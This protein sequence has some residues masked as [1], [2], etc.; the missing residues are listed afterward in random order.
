[1]WIACLLLGA[2]AAAGAG[3]GAVDPGFGLGGRL[4]L[5]DGFDG[6]V[7]L[8]E[9]RLQ[10]FSHANGTLSVIR[11][12]PAGRPQSDFGPGGIRQVPLPI[13]AAIIDRA[14]P[15]SD[16]S[17]LV[18]LRA[19]GAAA[20]AR[21]TL[22]SVDQHGNFEPEFGVGGVLTFRP[23]P[24]LNAQV[25]VES[26]AEAADGGFHILVNHAS[27]YFA[28][29]SHASVIHR[30]D[31][32]GNGIPEFSG[33]YEKVIQPLSGNACLEEAPV[34]KLWSLPDNRLLAS[35]PFGQF[36]FNDGEPAQLP[37]AWVERSDQGYTA[38]LDAGDQ[39]LYSTRPQGQPADQ[40]VLLRWNTDLS[41]DLYFGSLG[42]GSVRLDLSRIQSLSQLF[43]IDAI[44]LSRREGPDAPLYVSGLA[45][46]ESPRPS[47]RQERFVHRTLANG[48][49]D[50]T[51]G[52]AG[53][54]HLG[55]AGSIGSVAMAQDEGSLLFRVAGEQ[56]RYVR[57]ATGRSSGAGLISLGRDLCY[58]NG[59]TESAGDFVVPVQ[60]TVGSLG[61]VSVRYSARGLSATAGS[62]FVAVSGVLSWA[63]G[64]AGEKLIHLPILD[65]PLA[66]ETEALEILLEPETGS[67]VISC[68]SA[69]VNIVS[70]EVPLPTGNT[71][72]A[73]P[74]PSAP[75]LPQQPDLTGGSGSMG[76]AAL[77]LLAGTLLARMLHG[78]FAAHRTPAA[79]KLR[80]SSLSAASLL[81]LLWMLGPI[82]A[83][84]GV[85]D[86][87][88]SYSRATI[89]PGPVIPLADGRLLTDA[90]PGYR[91]FDAAGMPDA[92]FGTQGV[93]SWPEDFE[94]N[95]DAWL[96]FDDG[97]TLLGGT[98]RSGAA[99]IRLH[100]A[101]NLDLS[102]ASNGILNLPAGGYRRTVQDMALQSDGR[103]LVLT[104]DYSNIPYFETPV[105]LHVQRLDA[106]L[107]VDS[108][109][110][111]DGVLQVADYLLS[112][113]AGLIE[114][115]GQRL[116]ILKDGSIAIFDGYPADDPFPAQIA[117][118]LRIT[119]VSASG[120][121]S[122]PPQS[123]PAL[124]AGIPEWRV[125]A[126][127]PAGEQLVEGFAS[128][129]GRYRLY[130]LRA[131][132]LADP[133]F[134]GTEGFTHVAGAG[135]R[136]AQSRVSAD[137]QYLLVAFEGETVTQVLRI[138]LWGPGMGRLDETF[139]Q[140]GVVTIRA[141]LGLKAL[142]G[143]SDGS[144][145]VAGTGAPL[146]LLGVDLPS[147]GL[148]SFESES[149]YAPRLGP[150]RVRITRSA[151]SDGEVSVD[152]RTVDP[153]SPYVRPLIPGTDYA[154]V[155]SR[156]S[157][158]DG[159]EGA[160]TVEI[161][162]LRQPSSEVDNRSLS[163]GVQLADPRGGADLLLP[164][165]S[166]YLEPLPPV[167]VGGGAGGPPPQ[168]GPP[169]GNVVPASS[170]GGG[171]VGLFGLLGC[172]LLWTGGRAQWVRSS[173]VRRTGTSG[174]ADRRA[175][176]SSRP[177]C[178]VPPAG[179]RPAG[180]G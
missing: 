31:R 179:P 37:R 113:G 21:V 59:A 75:S 65:D 40:V 149:A 97:S 19:S 150:A 77:A 101:G 3:T 86:I 148:L 132:G 134:G 180:S 155:S 15:R 2:S 81:A 116:F 138:Q 52:D 78:R 166:I 162:F 140:R 143:M 109:F 72:P 106:S 88:P 135:M 14:W 95:W 171:S 62:D 80:V 112:G 118:T 94:P 68:N 157:W 47:G 165:Q 30:F 20:Q 164:K 160:W 147:P 103:L 84:A 91:R 83:T 74:G 48:A 125:V 60:R 41:P 58:A 45:Y 16:G 35:T 151:G 23:I 87:D 173:S 4:E 146:R 63:D 110:G 17:V 128:S 71:P 54:L 105:S 22:V 25:I 127:L 56:A 93:Q 108:T 167:V 102:F 66:E 104:A 99:L 133:A 136:H 100:S 130:R 12:D 137:G 43:A 73:Q 92:G 76:L 145:L 46:S 123:I 139:G 11:L 69:R 57:L 121:P 34:G 159:N 158:P 53:S 82:P 85:G 120:R 38:L 96:R 142:Q 33:Q 122:F 153:Q 174:P 114:I 172:L 64:E 29:C 8:P 119:H 163:F 44:S 67:P 111:I 177:G 156:I 89:E 13:G 49:S 161:P 70:E 50:S 79:C 55:Y 175:A 1:M 131:D 117:T 115:T 26:V 5:P 36:L 51:F 170:G 10:A 124:D 126:F 98:R 28:E 24:N 176:G 168:S 18:S 6:L 152:F 169:P 9:G 178:W 154:P 129:E 27:G 39:Y 7:A 42:D 90:G 107:V 141:A 144:V 61:A 32:E